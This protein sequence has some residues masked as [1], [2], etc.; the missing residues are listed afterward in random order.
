MLQKIRDWEQQG[1][2]MY[3][4]QSTLCHCAEN[5]GMGIDGRE[6]IDSRA[7]VTMLLMMLAGLPSVPRRNT[8]V[9]SQWVSRRRIMESQGNAPSRS[10]A[11]LLLLL[12][13]LSSSDSHSF[14][15]TS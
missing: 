1:A 10:A 15:I 14:G 7:S 8:L 11:V 3:V 4:H 9:S 13:T 5:D 12:C 2:E 6:E